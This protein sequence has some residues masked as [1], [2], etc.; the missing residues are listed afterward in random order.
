MN[1]IAH[2][3]R[4]FPVGVS[5]IIPDAVRQYL[6]YRGEMWN[7]HVGGSSESELLIEMAGRGCYHSW[8]NPKGKTTGE[9]VQESII[10]HKHGS[11][12]EHPWV[13]L[14]LADVPRSV[15]MEVLR[16]GD[17]TAF[18]W[19][20]QRFTDKHLRV[21]VPPLYRD[22]A[23]LQRAFTNMCENIGDDYNDL[24]NLEEW[25][26]PSLAN[27][28]GTIK[29]K[30]LKE[31]ARSILGN[32][33]GADG[34]FS[35]NLRAARHIIQLRTA[36]DADQSIRELFFEVY[37]VIAPMFPATFADAREELG[38]GHCRSGRIESVRRPSYPQSSRRR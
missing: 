13:N 38:I 25:E 8:S 5:T 32:C 16:H 22:N 27:L 2:A 18:S 6:R 10:E 29:K 20:S 17:G 33:A 24:A 11:V 31:A 19:E 30:R 4:V 28:S 23:G 14:M 9:Y 12:L 3:P 26:T 35:M 34:M 1:I 7:I 37:K 36:G 21:V 15:E